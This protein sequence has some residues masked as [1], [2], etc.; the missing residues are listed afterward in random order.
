MTI[1][2]TV[3]GALKKFDENP[4]ALRTLL[5]TTLFGYFGM[6]TLLMLMSKAVR[7]RL[8]GYFMEAWGVIS[9]F[10][11]IELARGV[12]F[13]LFINIGLYVVIGIAVQWQAIWEASKGGLSEPGVDI[14]ASKVKWFS[15]AIL[16]GPAYGKEWIED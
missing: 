7:S 13:W 16:Y 15:E 2:E 5:F 4:E 10:S 12:A 14:L 11:H 9:G 1:N 8:V 3:N 6:G